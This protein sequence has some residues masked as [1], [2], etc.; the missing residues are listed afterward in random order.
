MFL[1][2]C[3]LLGKLYEFIVAECG[4]FLAARLWMCDEKLFC[5]RLPAGFESFLD[6]IWAVNIVESTRPL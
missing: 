6:I 5:G 3:L 2:C 1:T 4:N